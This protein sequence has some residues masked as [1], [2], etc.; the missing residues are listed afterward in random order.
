M[1]LIPKIFFQPPLVL[2][3]CEFYCYYCK[4]D[5]CLHIIWVPMCQCWLKWL[6]RQARHTTYIPTLKLHNFIMHWNQRFKLYINLD[7]CTLQGCTWRGKR[8]VNLLQL[9]SSFTSYMYFYK[10]ILIIIGLFLLPALP[11]SPF[12][13]L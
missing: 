11:K 9:D 2:N 8:T 6:H 10:C 3:L 7:Q 4:R 12:I 13:L 5:S 1:D